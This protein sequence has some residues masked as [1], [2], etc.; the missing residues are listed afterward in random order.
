MTAGLYLLA[1]PFQSDRSDL[2]HLLTL[3]TVLTLY[4]FSVIGMIAVLRRRGVDTFALT[5]VAIFF[6][7]DPVFMGDAF[8][9]LSGGSNLLLTTAASLVALVK[10]WSLSRA[11]GYLLTPW[12][13]GWVAAALI[14][15]HLLPNLNAVAAVQPASVIPQVLTW[16]V[17][18][19]A[20]PL[21]RD[22]RLGRAALG[23]VAVHFIA[24]GI[25][26]SLEFPVE[27][28]T[29]PLVALSALLPWPRL[30]W[31]PLPAALYTS[32]MRPRLQS[33]GS[34]AQGVGMVLV[35]LAFLLL[36]IGFW[37]NLKA[38]SKE[39]AAA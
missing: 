10:A 6:L 23:A 28:L 9:S 20:L 27:F 14:G 35:G 34:T 29:G 3:W 38:A 33:I 1:G 22:G 8:T 37:R 19:L 30:G 15:V 5:L 4:E 16:A 2:H 26:S 13:A 39:Q 32:P 7:A 25:V 31:M 36:G 21:W 11:C 17:A 24:T 18:G 12:R